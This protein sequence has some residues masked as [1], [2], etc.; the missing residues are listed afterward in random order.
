MPGAID[1]AT[2]LWTEFERLYSVPRP[3]QPRRWDRYRYRRRRYTSPAP[4]PAAGSS[5]GQTP[6]GRRGGPMSN[7]GN[8]SPV[9]EDVEV[10]V[11]PMTV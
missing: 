7:I 4:P 11:T 3:P 1:T 5:A 8:S 10:N 9:Q 2:I 6:A